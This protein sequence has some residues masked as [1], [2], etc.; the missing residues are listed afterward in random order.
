MKPFVS[1]MVEILL[2]R[3]AC[4]CIKLQRIH[5]ALTGLQGFSLKGHA[6]GGLVM[7]RSIEQRL[8]VT[9]RRHE[10]MSSVPTLVF[11]HGYGCDQSMWGEVEPR[12]RQQCSTVLYDL[13]GCGRSDLLAYDARRY[14]DLNAHAD[15]L[16][17]LIGTL[18]AAGPI[19]LIGHSV[20]ATIALLATARDESLVSRLILVAP[21]PRYTDCDGYVGGMSQQQADELLGFLEL[22]HVGWSEALAPAI[23]GNADRPELAGNLRDSFCRMDPNIAAHFARATFLSDHRDDLSRV[24]IPSLI[25]Q[26]VDDDI[27]PEAVGLFMQQ[28]MPGAKLVHLECQGHCPHVSHPHLVAAALAA[29]LPL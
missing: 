10:R 16:I 6:F 7:Q 28:Q 18:D 12:F 8:A 25:L 5:S 17:A 4:L 26:V 23:M 13:V 22:N 27:A 19:Y 20:G 1:G 11:V 15:D 2:S 9:H 3:D 21:S 29:F 24:S 14:G